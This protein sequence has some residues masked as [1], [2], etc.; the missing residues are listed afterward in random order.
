M[1]AK[2]PLSV[3]VLVPPNVTF[4]TAV[5]FAQ[6]GAESPAAT[7]SWTRCLPGG[8]FAST[9]PNE[10]MLQRWRAAEKPGRIS[11]QNGAGQEIAMIIS[12]RGLA[13]A[14]DALAKENSAAR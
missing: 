14:I 11:F 4:G 13:Q 12:L 1:E 2:D 3:T 7:L 8:C 10:E 6:E 9:V 5:R